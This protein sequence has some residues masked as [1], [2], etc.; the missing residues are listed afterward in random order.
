MSIKNKRN[1]PAWCA[2]VTTPTSDEQPAQEEESLKDAPYLHIGATAP[3][4]T[5]DE[6][7]AAKQRRIRLGQQR[8]ARVPG[9]LRNLV[10]QGPGPQAVP[11]QTWKRRAP[12]LRRLGYA[13]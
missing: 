11:L 8:A 6:A 3:S 1:S 7:R 13:A 12:I 4:R 9:E 5:K 10:K 2:D